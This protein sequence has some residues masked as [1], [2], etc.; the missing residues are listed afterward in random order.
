MR[1]ELTPL[2]ARLNF[3]SK[4]NSLAVPQNI[5]FSAQSDSGKP[6]SAGTLECPLRI[7][8]FKILNPPD[9]PGRRPQR[10][11]VEEST[12]GKGGL[13]E[14]TLVFGAWILVH[15]FGSSQSRHAENASHTYDC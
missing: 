12:G 15:R 3:F 6:E 10:L 11:I 14:R 5:R 4:L 1:G 2:E 8:G 13:V 7:P 9:R